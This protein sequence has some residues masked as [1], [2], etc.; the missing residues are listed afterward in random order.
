MTGAVGAG[1]LGAAPYNAVGAGGARAARRT[2]VPANLQRAYR[3]GYDETPIYRGE[4]TGIVPSE[5]TGPAYFSRDRDYAMGFARE[6]GMDAPREYRMKTSNFYRDYDPINIDQ[7]NRLVQSAAA[8][9]P[10]FAQDM[11]SMIIDGMPVRE[12]P[13]FAKTYGNEMA[14][15]N[16]A[17]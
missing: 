15:D 7:Y 14:A 11:L 1:Y 17:L 6:G 5:F 16:G 10:K 9:N 4:S 8:H 3:Q 12:F 2:G 13:Q